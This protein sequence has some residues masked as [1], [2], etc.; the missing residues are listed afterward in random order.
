MMELQQQVLQRLPH[1]CPYCDEIVLY[2]QMNLREGENLILCP[3]C[4]KTY[5]K[6]ISKPSGD[7]TK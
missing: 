3:T 6:I 7:E 2:E 4:K 5:V 1:R